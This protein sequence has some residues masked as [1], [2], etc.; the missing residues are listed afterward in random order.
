M[1]RYILLPLT[2]YL[3]CEVENDKSTDFYVDTLVDTL[4]EDQM[5]FPVEILVS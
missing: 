3:R 2:L 1:L 4:V 5:K